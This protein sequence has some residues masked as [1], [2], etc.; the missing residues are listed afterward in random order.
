VCLIGPACSGRISI[1]H[2]LAYCR[3]INL[4]PPIFEF[5]GRHALNSSVGQCKHT[6][7]PLF[8]H[9]HRQ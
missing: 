8:I 9:S 1:C 7:C 6:A 3:A 4:R 5:F 2:P